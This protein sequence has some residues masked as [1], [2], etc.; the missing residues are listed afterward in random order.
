VARE[1]MAV[2]QV[3]TIEESQLVYG[4]RRADVR[5]GLMPGFDATLDDAWRERGFGI[6]GLY[7]RG[8]RGRR[9]P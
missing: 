2:S 7:A 3:A 4:S 6:S 5:S 9:R 1:R 8:R